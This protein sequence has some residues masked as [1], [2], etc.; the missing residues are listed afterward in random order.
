MAK[1]P[2]A[3]SFYRPDSLLESFKK[4][5]QYA[6]KEGRIATIPDFVEARLSKIH[7]AWHEWYTTA[8][9]LYFGDSAAGNP[10]IMVAHGIGPLTT[11]SG[12]NTA[13]YMNGQSRV[14]EQD[15]YAVVDMQNFRKLEQGGFGEVSIVD[16][17]EYISIDTSVALNPFI[18][19][20]MEFGL[21]DAK[22]QLLKALFGPRCEEYLNLIVAERKSV[23]GPEVF[24]RSFLQIEAPFRCTTANCWA[25]FINLKYSY[26]GTEW[27]DRKGGKF[28]GIRDKQPL[29]NIRKVEPLAK[30]QDDVGELSAALHKL[31]SK[32]ELAVMLEKEGLL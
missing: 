16:A 2:R 27:Q 1:L 3:L 8:T 4:A 32:L 9:C 28:V 20:R 18:K 10:I 14:N 19:T 26:W 12:I 29:R 5:K 25:N 23:E 24:K 15:I 30:L 17:R 6:G 7:E 22:D 11:I 31:Q 21:P 13:Y